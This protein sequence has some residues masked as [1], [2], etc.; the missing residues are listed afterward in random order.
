MKIKEIRLQNTDCPN[1]IIQDPMIAWIY[2]TADGGR[3][4]AACRI[5]LMKGKDCIYDSG[6]LHTSVQN[7]HRCRIQLESHQRYEVWVEV[8]DDLGETEGARGCFFLSGVLPGEW[9]GAW[10]SNRTA[11]PQ[12]LGRTVHLDGKIRYAA[13]SAA[14]A[15]QYELHIN[16]RRPDA[17][18]LNGSW[19]EFHKRIHY[20]TWEVTDFLREGENDLLLEVGNGWYCNQETDRYFYTMDKGY[21]SFGSMLAGIL[22]LT[23]EYEDGR[24]VVIGTDAQWWASESETTYTNSY[25]AEDYDGRRRGTLERVAAFVLSAKEAPQGTLL[26]AQY[27]PV[28]VKRV[29]EGRLLKVL[30]D[31]GM[32]YDMGQN[33]SG[34]FEVTVSG[35]RGTKLY[36]WPLEK[37]DAKQEPWK[38]VDSWCSYVL[39]GEGEERWKPKFTYEAGRYLLIRQARPGEEN[40]SETDKDAQGMGCEAPASRKE[41]LTA[42]KA[43]SVRILAVRGYA[44]T[45][46]ARDVGSFVCSDYRYMQIHDLVKRAM[47]SNL[48]HVHTDCPTI[49]R[50]G[51][52]EGNHLM[53]PSLFYVKDVGCFWEKIAADVRDGQYGPGERDVDT[54]AFPYEYGSGLL[55]SIAPRYARFLYEGGEGSFWD[56]PSWGSSILFA[57]W[58][59][60]RFTGDEELLLENYETAKRYVDYLY[61]KYLNYGKI[62]GQDEKK[63]FLRHGL[64]DWGIEQN[65]GESR[66]NIETAYLY[67]DLILL[68]ETAGRAGRM[69]EQQE[70]LKRAQ[71]VLEE[72]NKELLLWNPQ[73]GEWAYDSY[74]KAGFTVTQA[75][76][77]IPLQFGMVPPDKKD[78][79]CRSFLICCEDH[80]LRCG[81]IGLPYILRTLGDLKRADIVSDMILQKVHPSYY[82]FIE[83][84]ETTMPEFWRDDARSRN[85]DMMGSVVEWFYR[86][87]AGISSED[88]YRTIRVEPVLP[89]SVD[90]VECRYEAITGTVEVK[91]QR[92]GESVLRIEACIPVNTAGVLAAGGEEMELTGGLTRVWINEQREKKLLHSQENII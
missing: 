44:V 80:R 81:E 19:T 15:G 7:G 33:M 10:I 56:I 78:S 31:G 47:E 1:G 6:E 26:P 27:P 42:E 14:G 68:A 74:D 73:T 87:V 24:R 88:G 18:V 12:Y 51:W 84:G 59:R 25:G 35:E 85:H 90:Y 29:Y 22:R 36:M 3:R 62:Y 52:Q 83:K 30:E 57:A 28:V 65:R 16:G 11:R 58:E 63:H 13:V 2:D 23:V 60:Y 45:S 64:G 4:Q 79:V 39:E 75:T 5:R 8:T 49:E 72:Y 92:I 66:E 37:L 48:N 20:R 67:R 17:S 32:L 54:G 70:Q 41:G 71:E 91:I 55:P 69:Q 50:L 40:L 43:A 61:D 76:Q 89:P 34:L 86:Y 53:A 46:G 21:R 9:G 77:A 38:T 82:R